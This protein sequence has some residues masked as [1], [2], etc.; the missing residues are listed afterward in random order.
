[1]R[2]AV[3]HGPGDIRIEDVAEPGGP[4]PGEV[5]VA[6]LWCGIC[7]TDVH[8]YT[9]GPIVTCTEPH[10][11]TGATLPQILGH[12]FS[13]AV[14]EVGGGVRHVRAGDRVSVM[15]LIYCG[16]C[17]YCRLGLN[18][19]CP[20][21]AATGLSHRWGGL[22]E[23]AI[24]SARQVTRLPGE[25]DDRQGALVEPIAVAAYGVDRAGVAPGNTVLVTGA[26]PIG[27][28]SSEYALARGATEV[29]VSEPNPRRRE[30]AQRMGVA[31]VFDPTST[32]V[33]GEVR[34]RTGGLGAHAAVECSGSAAGLDACLRAT[35]ARGVVAQ[36]GLHVA[37]APIDAFELAL[38][39]ITLVGVWC[40]P[41][42][43]WPR[44]IALLASGRIA[45]TPAVT[46]TLGIES[47]VEGFE[48]LI[49]PAGGDAKILIG[50]GA[51]TS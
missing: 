48:R 30:V 19:L 50:A 20:T 1:M 18:P 27:L 6:P 39:E 12:E 29:F 4:A 25:V 26:G 2:A 24:L 37:P 10:E 21:M 5:L 33:V 11:L 47:T 22:A 51:S 43:D 8:E 40:Y 34:E 32:D 15:P 9:H 38:R 13:A 42:T 16:D 23:A 45:G 49:D 28:L 41:V 3:Y 44:I 31:E 14:L 36:T 46:A 17:H 7:G 35:R